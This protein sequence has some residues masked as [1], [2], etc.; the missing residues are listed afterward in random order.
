MSRIPVPASVKGKKKR[1]AARRP[2]ALRR[3]CNVK[4]RHRVASQRIQ[5]YLVVLIHVFRI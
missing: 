4:L 3:H 1:T 2:H 5:D